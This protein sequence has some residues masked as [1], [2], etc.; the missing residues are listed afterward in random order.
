RAL[1]PATPLRGARQPP[2]RAFVAAQRREAFL[3]SRQAPPPHGS[4]APA[5]AGRGREQRGSD[6]G[7][8]PRR[9][10]GDWSAPPRAG[11]PATLLP[12]RAPRHGTRRT[13]LGPL[14]LA[15]A[16]RLPQS[17]IGGGSVAPAGPRVPIAGAGPSV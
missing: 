8:P 17:S 5:Q 16:I 1:P 4:V 13:R 11:A 12:R 3:S 7:M 14:A 9:N 2:L 10:S 15:R 6:P